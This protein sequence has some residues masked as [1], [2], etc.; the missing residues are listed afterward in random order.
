MKNLI[1]LFVIALLAVDIGM[2]IQ[3]RQIEARMLALKHESAAAMFKVQ[4][5]EEEERIL[6]VTGAVPI[7]FPLGQPAATTGETV[8]FFLIASVHDCTN[9][10]EDEVV[11]LNEISESH[12]RRIAAVRGYFVGEG[13][14]VTANRFIQHLS[15]GPAFPFRVQ[16]A[17]S[18]LPGATTP[19]VLV[20]RT[21]DRRIVDAY[22]PIP[23]DLT[24]RD[25]FYARWAAA[26]D[27]F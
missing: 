3:R 14:P 1:W 13:D 24:K 18:R 12:S 11:K 8:Q 5:A 9:S 20:V 19:L 7:S 21:R 2:L 15:P 22:K 10:I 23:Q 26:L 25:A 16:N 4:C 6:S 27:L 17:L